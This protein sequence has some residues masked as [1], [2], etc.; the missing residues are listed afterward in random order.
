MAKTRSES[1]EICLS[2]DKLHEST[3]PRYNDI[4]VNRYLDILTG[5][6]NESVTVQ[7]FSDKNKTDRTAAKHLTMHRPLSF[8]QL[9][10]KQEEGCGVF[11]MVNQCD[12]KGRSTNNVLKIRALFIDL[13]GSPWE[14]AAKMLL[15]HMRVESSPGRYHLYWKVN[16][17]SLGQ[18]KPIQQ[19]I[20]EKFNGDK[21]CVD[22]PRV[23]RVPGFYNLKNQPVMTQLAEV[24]DVLPYTTQQVIDG[25]GLEVNELKSTMQSPVV[26][27]FE[28]TAKRY[29][30]VDVYGE[31]VDLASWAAKNPLFDLLG[32]VDAQ[33]LIGDVNN[34]KQ[35]V[36][37][38]FAHE[39]TDPKSDMA[40]FISNACPPKHTAFDIHCMHS[41]CAGR[42]R[43]DFIAAMLREGIL[44]ASVLKTPAVQIKT[45][46]YSNYPAQEV[47]A[48][49]QLRILLPKE[50]RILLHLVHLSWLEI[51]GTLP[52]DY[53]ML[54]RSLGLDEEDWRTCRETL[55]KT[56]WLTSEDCRLFSPIFKREFNKAQTAL[57]KKVMGGSSGGKK[58]AA[59]RLSTP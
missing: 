3:L 14:P 39:H 33:I 35:H 5:C 52:D 53:W 19:A 28:P 7:F 29:E 6:N 42:D 55:I 4:M 24:N 2:N 58:S 41:H 36:K 23:L 44:S 43:L 1:A 8:E 57:M 25:L 16:D 34:G 46:P 31:V 9:K 17:C 51:D 15:P 13:D 18:F 47:A 49:L 40:T 59:N 10:K 50:F 21:S 30:Y 56:G 38:P 45:P 26:P 48:N 32:N 11:V 12:G 37:C 27:R 22:L 54:A 20:A